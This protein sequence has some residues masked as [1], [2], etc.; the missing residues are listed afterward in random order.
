MTEPR[1][2][3]DEKR[4][5]RKREVLSEFWDRFAERDRR[6]RQDRRVKF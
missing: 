3:V 2:K 5:L 6:D 1:R 4:R